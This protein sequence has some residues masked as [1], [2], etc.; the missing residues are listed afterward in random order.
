MKNANTLKNE[1]LDILSNLDESYFDK[2]HPETKYHEKAGLSGLFLPSQPDQYFE[3]KNKIM[4]IGAET[5]GWDVQGES[6]YSNL[7]DYIDRSIAKQKNFFEKQLSLKNTGKITFHDFTRAV[8]ERSGSDGLLYCNL[9][10]FSWRQKS[11]IKT[12][13]FK[14]IH[15]VSK[16]LLQ[17]QLN[18]FQPNYIIL[19][20]GLSSVKYRR[21]MFPLDKCKDSTTFESNGITKNQLWQFNFDDKYQCFRIQHPS[22]IR[23]RNEAKIA[24]NKL[25]ELLPSK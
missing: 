25:L 8:S 21:E 13:Y 17:A 14:E 3:A 18:Y 19:A 20:N 5:R 7:K 24:R 11:P 12:K 2:N 10:A 15:E 22:T 1:Y 16:R 23:G 6:H 4:I 9:F